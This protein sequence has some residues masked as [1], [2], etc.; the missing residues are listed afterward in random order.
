M[1]QAAFNLVC[2]PLESKRKPSTIPEAQ[3]S[4]PY[5]LGVVLTKQDI[6]LDDFSAE[7]ITNSEFLDNARKV[8]VVVD[9]E[10]E[11]SSGRRIGPAKIKLFSKK[12]TVHEYKMT[13]V[14]GQPQNPMSMDD[15]E[16]KFERC[17]YCSAFT[18]DPKQISNTVNYIKKLEHINDTNLIVSSLCSNQQN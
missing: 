12:G 7:A 18:L 1:N 8:H 5:C 14:K 10:I 6:F 9:P 11:K 17:C 2:N 16:K 3:S 15:L 13:T 4:L